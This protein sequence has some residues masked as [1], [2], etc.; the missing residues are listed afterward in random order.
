MFPVSRDPGHHFPTFVTQH[1]KAAL[2]PHQSDDRIHH[3]LKNLIHLE[4]GV[5]H[6]PDIRQGLEMAVPLLKRDKQFADL[7]QRVF[8]HLQPI[9]GLLRDMLEFHRVAQ[10]NTLL[11]NGDDL[12]INGDG[13]GFD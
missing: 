13:L 9:D 8:K 1:Q 10:F 11:G 6:L 12:I 7:R 5:D 2:G 4:R 3:D